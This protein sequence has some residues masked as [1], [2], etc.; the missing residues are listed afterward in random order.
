MNLMGKRKLFTTNHPK[1]FANNIFPIKFEGF[2]DTMLH[3]IKMNE[4][5]RYKLRENDLSIFLVLKM[6]YF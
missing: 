4:F 2:E 3:K 6:K 1:S 5:D